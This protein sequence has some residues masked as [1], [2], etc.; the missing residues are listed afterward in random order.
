MGVL[1]SCEMLR[2]RVSLATGLSRLKD[3]AFEGA[4]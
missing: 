3:V 2:C 1:D 4:Q